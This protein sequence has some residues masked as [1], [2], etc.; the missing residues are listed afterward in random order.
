MCVFQQFY[1]FVTDE[2]SW[3]EVGATLSHYV[4][5]QI[6]HLVLL[7][8]TLTPTQGLHVYGFIIGSLLSDWVLWLSEVAVTFVPVSK[9]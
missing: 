3:A 7:V 6:I 8:G 4:I 1:L 9:A 5:F 2:G